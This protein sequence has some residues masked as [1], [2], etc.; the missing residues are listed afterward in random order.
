MMVFVRDDVTTRQV[1]VR[2][3]HASTCCDPD[4]SHDKY[5]T[6]SYHFEAASMTDGRT[7]NPALI[8]IAF[9]RRNTTASRRTGALLCSLD[10]DERVLAIKELR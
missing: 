3:A 2:D 9:N 8:C 7:D 10:C 6:F 4:V 5:S 1:P